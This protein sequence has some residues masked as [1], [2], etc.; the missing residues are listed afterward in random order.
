M[1]ETPFYGTMG[2]QEGDKGVIV[3]GDAQF[4]CGGHHSS[5]GRQDRPCGRL[6]KGMLNTGDNVT[7]NVDAE[8][9]SHREEPQRDPSS[10]EGASHRAGRSCGAGRFSGHSGQSPLRLY[11]FLCHDSRGDQEGGGEWSMKRSRQACML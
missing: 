7:L 11:P 8:S 9:R 3:L 1:E 2:G 10:A 5:A 4:R 6:T